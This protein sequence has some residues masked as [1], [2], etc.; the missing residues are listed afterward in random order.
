MRFSG[1]LLASQLQIAFKTI[2]D[3]FSTAWRAK[4]DQKPLVFASE[5]EDARFCV[6]LARETDLVSISAPFWSS[7]SDK[8]FPK[9]TTNRD[10]PM[11]IFIF[12]PP[13]PQ[14][15]PFVPGGMRAATR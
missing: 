12:Y 8:C 2:F 6:M 10:R 5:F 4:N 3:E 11:S 13:F 1:V 15:V 7:K 14:V 9:E